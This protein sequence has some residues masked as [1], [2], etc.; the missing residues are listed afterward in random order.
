MN[1]IMKTLIHL[2]RHALYV[3]QFISRRMEK[4]RTD[5]RDIS[6]LTV[7]SLLVI[8]PTPYSTGLILLWTSGFTSLNVKPQTLPI[9]K[10]NETAN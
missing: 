2:I 1:R 8:E 4:I 3:V 10:T 7:T 6:V 9:I 5:I